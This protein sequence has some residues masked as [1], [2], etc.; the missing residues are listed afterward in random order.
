VTV[1][2]LMHTARPVLLVFAG[3]ACAQ[4]AAPRRGRVDMT[5][6]SCTSATAAA[7]LIRPD[8][9]VAWAAEGCG[10]DDVDGSRAALGRWF[11]PIRR[12]T[13]TAAAVPQTLR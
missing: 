11:G 4:S 13:Q 5:T 6:T 2:E 8:G 12:D 7:I 10:P 9:Y 3:G 1:A